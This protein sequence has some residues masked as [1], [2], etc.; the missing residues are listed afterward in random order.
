VAT[1]D[2]IK[3]WEEAESRFSLWRADKEMTLA[4]FNYG[5]YMEKT[6][7]AG[8]IPVEVF[9]NRGIENIYQEVM[10]RRDQIAE[11]MRLQQMAG[12]KG[13]EGLPAMTLAPPDFTSFDTTGF[14]ES[15]ATRVAQILSYFEGWLGKYPF[16]KLSV[17]QIPG[18]AGQG[19]PSLLYVSSLSFFSPQQ[20]VQLGLTN[21]QESYFW[22]CLH[23]HEIAHQWWGNQTVGRSYRD[24]WIFEGFANYFG[25]LSLKLLHSND[26]SFRNAMHRSLEIIKKKNEDG[27]PLD[28]A[29]SVWLGTRLTSSK[30]PSG[31]FRLI[32]EKG[33][34]ILHMLHYLYSDP[35]TGNDQPFREVLQEFLS[36][37][38][39]KLAGTE[40][41]KK[42]LEKRML[43]FADLE[44]NHRLDWFFDEWIYA[45][46][47]P[48]YRLTYTSSPL[49]QGGVLIKAKIHQDGVP[50]TFTMPLEIFATSALDKSIKEKVGRVVTTG[51]E[52]S[53][54][55]RLKRKP[56][57]LSLDENHWILCENHTN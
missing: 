36:Q 24:L 26:T 33:A 25:Y 15:I 44:G 49:P 4:G 48:D 13:A 18:P 38:N 43:K 30:N 7:L 39:G 27:V 45:T 6:V 17:S 46:G 5:D 32:Y 19:W 16:T 56:A 3:E 20:R 8:T 50:D 55:L 31:Y 11:Q 47:I 54:Q 10:M 42:V 22:E 1:G 12:R 57:K 53:F 41:L 35:V 37:Y 9:A 52:T 28:E 2:R 40:E 14:A 21:D 51:P 23:A 34:W 29:G